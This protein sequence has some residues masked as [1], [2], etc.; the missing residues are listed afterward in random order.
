M[1]QQQPTPVIGFLRPTKAEESGHLL[2]AL[3]QGLRESGYPGDKV[4]IE[5]RWGDGREEGLPKL[6]AELAGLNVA[7]IVV[8]SIAAA[9]AAKT[10]TSNVPIIF[11][12]GADPVA[13]G[14]VSSLNRP[15]GNMTGVSFYDVPIIGKRLALLRELVPK[16]ETI[17]VL[18]DPTWPAFQTES[19]EIEN[20]AR[21]MGQKIMTVKAS[22]EQEINAAFST[23]A[24]SSAGALL[25][26]GGAFLMVGLAR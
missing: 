16:A 17:A 25:V 9:R 15:D 13:A 7:A 21:A 12:T 2:A 11:V 22:S 8:G 6:V 14:L 5:P 10:T 24:K 26:G 18:Q 20:A 19:R 4:V 1:L 3:R 23:V